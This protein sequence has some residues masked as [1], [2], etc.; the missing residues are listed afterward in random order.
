[1]GFANGMI[2]PWVKRPGILDKRAPPPPKT[3]SP[4]GKDAE[5]Q[6]KSSPIDSEFIDPETKSSM[7]S[8][9]PKSTPV[10]SLSTGFARE[11]DTKD[12]TRLSLCR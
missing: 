5:N 1:M 2:A 7:V 11:R 3:P 6:R 12:I 8:S 10:L 9:P 4:A